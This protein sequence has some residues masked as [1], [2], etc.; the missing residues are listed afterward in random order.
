LNVSL[1]KTTQN[2]HILGR[3][4]IA[5]IENREDGDYEKVLKKYSISP[6]FSQFS[7]PAQR[8]NS[9][10]DA[11]AN[12][13]SNNDVE[14]KTSTH[15]KNRTVTI[16]VADGRTMPTREVD[17][18]IFTRISTSTATASPNSQVSPE[19]TLS[20][21]ETQLLSIPLND[22]L[23]KFSNTLGVET[24]R[25]TRTSF[26]LDT[27]PVYVIPRDQAEQS[28]VRPRVYSIYE[29]QELEWSEFFDSGA[30]ELIV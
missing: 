28:G 8:A 10:C 9:W 14:A 11:K 27:P 4:T 17:P 16:A 6:S 5:I 1:F 22:T 19:S 21:N 2:F 24:K 25:Q 7:P 29:R 30:F 3:N 15:K 23:P 26:N 20:L 13:A 12:S 18:E